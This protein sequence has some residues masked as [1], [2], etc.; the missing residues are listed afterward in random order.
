MVE[1]TCK[2]GIQE[3]EGRREQVQ[4]W[5]TMRPLQQQK[6]RNESHEWAWQ[7]FSQTDDDELWI[8]DIKKS[9]GIATDHTDSKR[10]KGNITDCFMQR[11]CMR[12]TKA[13]KDL[14]VSCLRGETHGRA[15]PLGPRSIKGAH[16]KQLPLYG[17]EG[18]SS[19]QLV[20]SINGDGW[21]FFCAAC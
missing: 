13:L 19:L 6:Q 4:A 15:H 16:L 12:L 20:I 17:A 21:I 3:A 8:H 14:N 9:K 11:T 18:P 10:T 2:P 7:R 1:H 5:T